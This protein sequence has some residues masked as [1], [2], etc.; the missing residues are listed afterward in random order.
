MSRVLARRLKGMR[1]EAG[2]SQEQAA[3]LTG[4]SY[5][6]YRRIESRDYAIDLEQFLAIASA[7]DLDDRAS[8]LFKEI[9][10]TAWDELLEYGTAAY[11]SHSIS[12]ITLSEIS[13]LAR[14]G[15]DLPSDPHHSDYEMR[16]REDHEHLLDHIEQ[17]RGLLD[18]DDE[19][20]EAMRNLKAGIRQL[21]RRVRDREEYMPR[22]MIE[23]IE[24][25]RDERER[26][27]RSVSDGTGTVQE[28]PIAARVDNDDAESEA[29]QD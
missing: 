14:A 26:R 15:R 6:T 7:F 27:R 25:A 28:L 18:A 29:Q 12:D 3:A 10:D 13:L 24:Q 19:T 17:L 22:E 4:I 23:S 9:Y 5:G 21:E 11:D 20:P 8:E 16:L 2:L 1:A